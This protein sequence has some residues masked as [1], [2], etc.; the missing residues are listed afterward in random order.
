ME[1]I[2]TRFH[3][4]LKFTNFRENTMRRLIL[5]SWMLT[6]TITSTT[7]RGT[8]NL[9]RSE[10]SSATTTPCGVVLWWHLR[11]RPCQNL[12]EPTWIMCWSSTRPW[13]PIQGSKFVNSLSVMGLLYAAALADHFKIGFLSTTQ[14]LHE[15][16]GLGLVTRPI[17]K[18]VFRSSVK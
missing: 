16:T 3:C 8:L 7:T 17:I 9:W 11:M 2:F 6:K 15:L 4:D 14:P 12:S 18:Y 5:S 1:I 10:E 13:L